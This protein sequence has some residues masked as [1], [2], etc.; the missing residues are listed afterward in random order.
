MHTASD[1][2]P[3]GSYTS[4]ASSIAETASA[5]A[6]PTRLGTAVR[7]SWSM[8]MAATT[9][10]TNNAESPAA[11]IRWMRRGGQNRVV[12]RL[13]FER[14]ESVTSCLPSGFR[15]R[16]KRSVWWRALGAEHSD[17]GNRTREG[18]VFGG[19]RARTNRRRGQLSHSPTTPA[20]E[21][22]L[23]AQVMS[24]LVAARY[25][26]AAPPC[27]R[28]R[29]AYMEWVFDA[30]APTCT[31]SRYRN[32]PRGWPAVMTPGRQVHPRV[33]RLWSL[34]VVPSGEVL[35]VATF[36]RGLP[37]VARH[38]PCPAASGIPDP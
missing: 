10:T 37:G 6:S 18:S 33:G 29:L 5:R 31:S 28:R 22:L 3:S 9:A 21:A 15:E 8:R 30:V 16:E 26:L 35:M 2:S 38:H 14:S 13:W 7:E 12:A 19:A 24:C 4:S 34:G 1:S 17:A 32:A 23:R 36:M 11:T 25:G 20:G 27:V